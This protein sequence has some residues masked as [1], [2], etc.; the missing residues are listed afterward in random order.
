MELMQLKEEISRSVTNGQSRDIAIIYSMYEECN[1]LF[2]DYYGF[3]CYKEAMNF[4]LKPLYEQLIEMKYFWVQRIRTITPGD[5]CKLATEFPEGELNL[6]ISR[7][8]EVTD[9][10]KNGVFLDKTG[11]PLKGQY[12]IVHLIGRCYSLSRQFFELNGPMSGSLMPIYSELVLLR[13]SL[14]ALKLH[15]EVITPEKVSN[16]KS[17]VVE[18]EYLVDGS[19]PLGR[20]N[21]NSLMN[22]CINLYA[23]IEEKLFIVEYELY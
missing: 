2:E 10:R 19:V 15:K 8:E 1:I 9:L 22:E 4:K 11:K 16:C 23:D 13:N 17:E 21:L 5:C 14:I 20:D 6:N 12:A 3:S 7:L 18:D